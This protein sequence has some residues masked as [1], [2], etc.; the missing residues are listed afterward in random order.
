MQR[1][2]SQPVRH[3]GHDEKQHG[4]LGLQNRGQN[5]RHLLPRDSLVRLKIS[6]CDEWEKM[7]FRRFFNRSVEPIALFNIRISAGLSLIGLGT[8]GVYDKTHKFRSGHRPV[9]FKKTAANAAYEGLGRRLLNAGLC[10]KAV[11]DIREGHSVCDNSID[12]VGL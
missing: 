10:P 11:R 7:Q 8:D 9:R 3:R 6:V 12:A 2:R 4:H 5:N 1:V